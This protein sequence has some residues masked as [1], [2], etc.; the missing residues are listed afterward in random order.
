MAPQDAVRIDFRL[1]FRVE[2]RINLLF[3]KVVAK[4][5]SNKE[6]TV[7][8]DYDYKDKQNVF[9]DISFVILKK[10]IANQHYLPFYQR[11]IINAYHLINRLSITEEQAFGINDEPNSV[12]IEQVPI[13]FKSPRKNLIKLNRVFE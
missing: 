9:G 4:L 3:K 5:I 6:I 7:Q 10:F 2:P 13:T 11:F 12:I 8:T 1:G